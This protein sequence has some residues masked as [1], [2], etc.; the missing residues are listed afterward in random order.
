MTWRYKFYH[1]VFLLSL[2][3]CLQIEGDT[4][5]DYFMNAWEA[6]EYG[7][8]DAVIDD[9]KPGLVAP[10]A[11]AVPPPKTRVWDLWKIEG[12]RKARKNLP[13]EQKVLQNGY[14]GEQG[15]DGDKGT[16]QSKEAATPV[17]NM[18][19]PAS[20]TIM[21]WKKKKDGMNKGLEI[22]GKLRRLKTH[23]QHQLGKILISVAVE[24]VTIIF[25]GI[26]ISGC[27]FWL[28]W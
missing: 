22:G 1:F 24:M 19:C 20:C 15:S 11:D 12:S 14:G 13:S 27:E 3:P 25:T 8:V 7:L 17:W 21:I 18:G 9:G 16:E 5:R 26:V 28:H 10:I 6:K 2:F 4:D 23:E